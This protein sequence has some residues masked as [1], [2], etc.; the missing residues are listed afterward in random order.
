MIKKQNT[1]LQNTKHP[2]KT[3]LHTGKGVTLHVSSHFTPQIIWSSIL[4]YGKYEEKKQEHTRGST[5]DRILLITGLSIL[6]NL[7]NKSNREAYVRQK[8]EDDKLCKIMHS[9]TTAN[10][11]LKQMC[12]TFNN[13]FLS[14]MEFWGITAAILG[15][16][17]VL[18]QPIN[19]MAIAAEGKA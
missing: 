2:V 1:T 3:C 7:L 17:N 14:V 15:R 8:W 5:Q 12:H 19:R 6:Q 4:Q 16:R 18:A 13:A 10:D 9:H 11:L